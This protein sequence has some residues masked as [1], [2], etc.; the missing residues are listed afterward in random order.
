MSN[1]VKQDISISSRL[2]GAVGTVSS[3]LIQAVRPEG[4]WEGY[5]SSSALSTATAVSALSVAA[6]SGDGRDSHQ[7][8]ITDGAAWLRSHQNAD[9]GWGDTA[10]SPSN[11]A[12]TI[13]C[14]AALTLADEHLA[15]NDE[16]ADTLARARGHVAGPTA[17]RSLVAAVTE[18]YGKDR[19]FA[20]P[21]LANCALAGLVAWEEIPG[22][23]FE[24]AALPHNW[25][26]FLRLHVVSYALP[27]L[28]A[29]GLLL[30]DRKASRG[31]RKLLR[32]LV[33]KR[34]LAKL[35]EI[36]PAN[37]GFLEAIPL[38][39]FVAMTLIPLHGADHPVAA[40]CLKFIEGSARPDGSWAIDS[41]LSV[42]VTT[43]AVKALAAAGRI[44]ELDAERTRRWI[45]AQQYRAI[46]PYTNSAPGAWGWTHLDGGVPDTDDTA[47]AML[48]LLELGGDEGIREGAKWL[49]KIQNRDGGWPTFSKGWG[50]L[51]FDKSSPDLTA[52]AMMA[53]SAMREKFGHTS[54]AVVR[55]VGRGMKYLARA[56]RA[57]GSWVPLW[58]GNQFAPGKLNPVLGTSVVL[59]SLA[60]MN[61]TADIVPA[62]VTF[63]LNAQNEDGGWGGGRGV[64]SSVEESS[65][66]IAALA[67]Y[68]LGSAKSAVD[69]GADYLLRR[70]EAGT[71][72]E[73]TPIGLY[74][75][76]LWYSEELY[77]VIWTLD[78]LSRLES[79]HFAGSEKGTWQ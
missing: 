55:A 20:V 9:G 36:Q 70:V 22:L 58:F 16:N 26:K 61:V 52:H 78:A 28:I 63:L 65:L 44:C 29:I 23:P 14:V 6:S 40:R 46:H 76:R 67:G 62:G 37:G 38:T 42:W 19:T 54:A 12:T 21:I 24:L 4:F 75:A 66:A 60:E 15:G 7:K 2:N 79:N 30:D 59:K 25:Y 48:A 18:A 53:L 3:C 1:R 64:T 47:S 39:S 13:L 34:A 31:P 41:N 77:P 10:D 32:R 11:L 45:A 56:Q 68:D 50:K 27:A 8:M 73:K 57:D 74:F 51:P 72:R 35:G 49:L 5:L 69:R 33:E 43:N 17:D 71:W